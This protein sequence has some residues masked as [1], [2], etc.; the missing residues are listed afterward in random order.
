MS[1]SFLCLASVNAGIGWVGGAYAKRKQI[2]LSSISID[3]HNG[4]LQ[5]EPQTY[6]RIVGDMS[7]VV[8][9]MIRLL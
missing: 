1:A 6:V 2:V 5:T 8:L 4:K 9:S 3:Y 7:I